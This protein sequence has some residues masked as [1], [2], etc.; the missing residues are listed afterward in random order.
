MSTR[1]VWNGCGREFD[2][3]EA[4]NALDNLTTMCRDCHAKWE[5][6]PVRPAREG[7]A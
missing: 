1:C 7:E 4:A 3:K 2:E 5:G 6:I